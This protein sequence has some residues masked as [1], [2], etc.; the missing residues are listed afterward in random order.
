[1][2]RA[3]EQGRDLYQLYTPALNATALERLALESSLRKALAHDELLLHYQPIFDVATRRVHGVEALLRW[4]HPE[5]GLVPPAEF[6]PLAEVTGLILAIGPWVLRAACAQARAWQH[7]QPGLRVA[8]NLSARQFQEAGLVGHVTDALADTGLDPRCLHLEITESSAM[9]NAQTAIQTLRELKA[10]G[11]GLSIDDFGTGYSSL[12]YL[13]RFPIDT[14][15]I[16]QSFI[17]DIGTDPDDA[18]IASAIIALAHTLKLTVVA[19]G[20]E[21]A[22]QLEFLTRHGCDR[23][24][25]YFFSRPLGVERCSELLAAPVKVAK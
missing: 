16:D 21:T 22:D 20:V 8:V 10:L 9:Q 18:A 11:V 13:K 2:Y 19:E 6:I 7:L 12:S 14:L 24:Q 17:R 23:T 4:H 1:M 5:L 25:G 15:K 3:K